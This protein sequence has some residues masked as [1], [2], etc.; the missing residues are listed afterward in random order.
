MMLASVAQRSRML[1]GPSDRAVHSLDVRLALVASRQVI[2]D[3]V[4][5]HPTATGD[6]SS[7]P[8]RPEHF[9]P[10]LKLIARSQFGRHRGLRFDDSDIVQETLLE[11]H[12]KFEQFRGTTEAELA[13]WLRK[14]L[15]CTLADAVRRAG[16]AKRDAAR[17][18][19][20]ERSI[21]DSCSRVTL[22]LGDADV[23]QRAAA[24]RRGS[25][26]P[27]DCSGRLART[28]ANCR[29]TAP[30]ARFVSRGDR[31]H[32]RSHR[33]GHCRSFEKRAEGSTGTPG[34]ERHMTRSG[35]RNDGRHE[36]VDPL[37]EI[38]AAF[39][40]AEESGAPDRSRLLREHPEHADE[41]REFF[42][43]RDRLRRLAGTIG[44]A[45]HPIAVLPE[46]TLPENIRYFGDYELLEEVARGGMG[47]VY[48]ARQVSL[49]RIVALKMIL[50]GAVRVGRRRPA[51]PCRGRSGGKLC[52]TP[53]I[54]ADPRGRPAPGTALLL[55]GLRRGTESRQRRCASIRYRHG[56][57]PS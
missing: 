37:D 40:R 42:A 27:R 29:R 7:R 15:A 10:Y 31:R 12:R 3:R 23:A 24:A 56:G 32:A 2:R 1:F 6:R 55:D 20:L 28:P 30:S 50:A 41:L 34:R 11:A 8:L 25:H 19:S 38:L 35:D 14:L 36:A 26:P 22:L 51:F 57:R 9:R 47:V 18:R 16:R 48:K 53:N 44:P 54:V 52:S 49:N 13:A 43:D 45:A 39:L 5:E 4:V 33:A 21:E 17:E 46:F